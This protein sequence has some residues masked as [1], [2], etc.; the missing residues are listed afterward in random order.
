MV[1][2]AK[3]AEKE[4]KEVRIRN[5]A[6]VSDLR[7]RLDPGVNVLLGPNG[8]GKTSAIR[9]VTRAFGG[10]V[11]LEVRDGA[12]Q[13]VVEAPGVK[14]SVKRVVRASGEAD[15]ALADSGPLATLIDPGMA[16]PDAAA[17][18]RIRALL[19]LVALPVTEERVATLAGDEEVA[20]S[21]V[22][23][24][25]EGAID[26]LLHAA[27]RCRLTAHA[28][29]R[30][31]EKQANELT[32]RAQV[33][34]SRMAEA[35]EKV[36]GE[37]SLVEISAADAEAAGHDAVQK[38][39]VARVS[40]RQ[41]QELESRQAEIRA[42]LGD[43]PDPAKFDQDI[44]ARRGAVDA[45]N[46][47]I[48]ELEQQISKERELLAGVREDLRHL[49]QQKAEEEKRAKQH[50]ENLRIL[51]LPVEGSTPEEVEEL[52]AGVAKARATFA[53]ARLAD[54]YRKAK[55]EAATAGQEAKTAHERAEV[56]EALATS[57]GNRL[58]LLLS[59][60]EAEGLT[61]VDGR[62]A[63]VEEGKVFD[64]ETRRS[65]GQR[66]AASLRVA[67]RAY[68]GKVIPL[69]GRFWQALDDGHR[70]EFAR[71]AADLGLY[72]ITEQPA[73][74]ELRVENLVPADAPA[75]AA[76]L[77]GAA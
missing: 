70:Q 57:V 19:E 38:L 8:A 43:P 7:L 18:A 31:T 10:K 24:L 25:R 12:G 41:R 36:G 52:E 44:E 74:G 55:A 63:V 73:E 26:D 75:E 33:A 58:G 14:L 15:V 20:E 47:R 68:G 42:Q 60:T 22:Q 4:G 53:A 59:G 11:P 66:I 39:E 17:R 27:E 9:A 5:V 76:E 2:R 21:V 16:D 34:E 45:H 49:E 37:A 32:A 29:K 13:G 35:L 30:E 56:L 61:V 23:E 72:V 65:E 51:E 6:G 48:L 40:A 69:E 50:G 46:R 1:A 62:L 77:G 64:F 71:L 54:D 67:A 3:A 28:L